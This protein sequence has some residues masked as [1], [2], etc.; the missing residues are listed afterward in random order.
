MKYD[1][2]YCSIAL[3]LLRGKDQFEL[4]ISVA[5]LDLKSIPKCDWCTQFKWI[6]I[7]KGAGKIRTEIILWNICAI[8]LMLL[9]FALILEI[10]PLKYLVQIFFAWILID[11]F[12]LIFEKTT[13][14]FS[15][16][17]FWEN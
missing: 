17:V 9:L 5:V 13:V 12:Q 6:Q 11:E 3:Y 16:I 10:K 8:L 7:Q 4:D 2:I 1:S 14:L 15:F